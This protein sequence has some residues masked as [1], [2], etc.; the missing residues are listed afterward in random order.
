MATVTKLGPS[1][2]GRPMSYEEFMA[3]DYEGSL[4]GFSGFALSALGNFTTPK[5][6]TGSNV[7]GYF[8][9]V[10]GTTERIS[11]HVTDVP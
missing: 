8:Y 2:H 7:T 10:G 1:D 3:G 4:I 5:N 9:S 11:F 6:I